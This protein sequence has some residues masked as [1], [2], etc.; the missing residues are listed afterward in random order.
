M[1]TCGA[2]MAGFGGVMNQPGI[3]SP[4]EA[5]PRKITYHFGKRKIVVKS[6]ETRDTSRIYRMSIIRP[7]PEILHNLCAYGHYEL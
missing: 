6:T 5:G 4:A 1:L 3:V 2:D 7:D